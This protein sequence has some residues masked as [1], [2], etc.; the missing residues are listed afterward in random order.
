MSPEKKHRKINLSNNIQEVL[1]NEPRSN[2]DFSKPLYQDEAV[3][4]KPFNADEY[5]KNRELPVDAKEKVYDEWGAVSMHNDELANV[6]KN[7]QN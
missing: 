1:G 4:L 2:R 5:L 6:L 3:I 7:E